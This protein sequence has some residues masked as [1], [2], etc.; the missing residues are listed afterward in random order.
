MY[1]KGPFSKPGEDDMDWWLDKQNEEKPGVTPA[2]KHMAEE[3]V[4]LH[5][6]SRAEMEAYAEEQIG[7]EIRNKGFTA[8]IK[9]AIAMKANAIQGPLPLGLF[10][11]NRPYSDQEL[12]NLSCMLDRGRK[13]EVK[14]DYEAREKFSMHVDSYQLKENRDLQW[15]LKKQN[16]ESAKKA[17]K[18]YIYK[19][20]LKK[21]LDWFDPELYWYMQTHA[22]RMQ[23]NTFQ[24]RLTDENDLENEM[25]G[26]TKYDPLMVPLPELHKEVTTEDGFGVTVNGKFQPYSLD[27]SARPVKFGSYDNGVYKTCNPDGF[28]DVPVARIPFN[29]VPPKL[30]QIKGICAQM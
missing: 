11:P 4:D 14:T 30:V 3:L 27:S 9:L 10:K 5:I 29:K 15:Y 25:V 24:D 2:T 21:Y 22:E 26:R 1:P 16:K 12:V 7:P 28:E 23:V 17:L 13:L 18:I 20:W 8:I 19:V 6:Y